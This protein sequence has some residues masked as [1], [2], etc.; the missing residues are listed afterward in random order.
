L[1]KNNSFE[2]LELSTNDWLI[3]SVVSIKSIYFYDIHQWSFYGKQPNDTFL[4]IQQLISS[5]KKL[6]DYY[7]ILNGTLKT[8]NSPNYKVLVEHNNDKDGVLFFSTV[9]NIPLNEIPLSTRDFVYDKIIPET[10]QLRPP[11]P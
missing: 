1:V 4:D 5:L 8:L 9:V 6:L 3:P 7:P 10:L 11:S 2:S